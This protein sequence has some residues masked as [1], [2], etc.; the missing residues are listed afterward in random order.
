MNVFVCREKRPLETRVALDP[1]AVLRWIKLGA[2]VTLES[3]AGLAA[4]HPDEAYLQ[5][6]AT[7]AVDPRQVLAGAD[8]VLR[9]RPPDAAE[10]SR[11]KPGSMAVGFMDPFFN[12]GLIEALV[13]AGVTGV[14]E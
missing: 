13:A 8:C 5:A 10:I 2:S 1:P 6:G 14:S 4:G 3:G 7:I 9:V 12:R 11:Q